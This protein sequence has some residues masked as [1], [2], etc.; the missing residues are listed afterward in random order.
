MFKEYMRAPAIDTC[1]I[2]CCIQKSECNVAFV[3]NER[4]FH[5]KC[6][7]NEECMP[8]ERTNMEANLKM[9]LINPTTPG[10]IHYY[11]LTFV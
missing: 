1:A 2:K 11:F 3:F 7:S 8:L 4:C 9:V 6:N 5:V 10:N